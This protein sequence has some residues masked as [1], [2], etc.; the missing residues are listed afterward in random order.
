MDGLNANTTT[1]NQTLDKK[2][3]SASLKPSD[4][5]NFLQMLTAAGVKDFS[6]FN[7]SVSLYPSPD[8]FKGKVDIPIPS[9]KDAV[10]HAAELARRAIE[11]D[12]L[13]ERWST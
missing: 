5:K 6:G 10:K 9:A 4:I 2:S 1:R 3:K 7:I 13:N 11:E 12:E 8:E